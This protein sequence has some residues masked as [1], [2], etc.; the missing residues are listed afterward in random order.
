VLVLSMLGDIGSRRLWVDHCLDR[1][2]LVVGEKSQWPGSTSQFLYI[3][4]FLESKYV[5]LISA[6]YKV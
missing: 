5:T 4:Y 3:E 1:N 2:D 6:I